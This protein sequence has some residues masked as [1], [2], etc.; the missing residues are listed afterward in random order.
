MKFLFIL[1]ICFQATLMVSHAQNKDSTSNGV[2]NKIKSAELKEK[3]INS[4]VRKPEADTVFNFKSETAFLPYEGKIIRRINVQPVHFYKTVLDTTKV[5]RTKIIQIGESFHTDTKEKTIRNNLFIKEGQQLNP[6]RLADNERYLRDLNFIKDSRIYVVQWDEDSDS[7]DLL[8]MTRDVFSLGAS[9]DPSSTTAA[10]WLLQE[11]NFLGTGLR[12]AYTGL[13]DSDRRPEFGSEYSIRQ[14]SI[15]GSFIDGT[16]GY[17]NINNARSIG[18]ENETAAYLRL[19]RPLFMPYARWAGSVEW[20][21]NWSNNVFVKPDSLFARYVYSIQDYWGGITF[22][23]SSKGKRENRNRKFLSARVLDQHF[24]SSPS[25][26]LTAKENLLYSNRVLALAQFTLFRQDFYK[27]KYIFGFGRTEDVPYGYSVSLTA[28][29]EKQIGLRRPYI[30][31]EIQKS[32]TRNGNII[33]VDSQLGGYIRNKN[34]EDMTLKLTASYFS[35]LYDFSNY[36]VRHS[37]EV[38]LSQFYRRTIKNPLDINNEN[39]IQ[40]FRADSLAGDSRLR[41]RLQALVFTNWKLLGFNF[42]IVP[43]F[44]FAFLAQRDESILSGEFFQ[45]YSLGLRTRNE[46]LIF[47]TV[48]IRGYFFPSTVENID[49]FRINISANLR[50]KYPTTLVRAPDTIF[51]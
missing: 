29:W 42:A 25:I 14:N 19:D 51:N 43:Q 41:T 16:V 8:V 44:D 46:N 32:F 36:K 50:I 24:I 2:L 45:G 20:S 49:H 27:T 39:G 15:R 17:T 13:Y 1:C 28:G 6:Y 18:N 33:S 37:F 12:F 48:E 26:E 10:N 22:G 31:G 23:E 30:G 3:A 38:G 7:V 21:R 4:I 35:K 34:T 5:V 40:G 9:L 47:N 11:G